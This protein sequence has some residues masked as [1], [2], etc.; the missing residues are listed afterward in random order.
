MRVTIPR[1]GSR[2]AGSRSPK[3]EAGVEAGRLVGL[4]GERWALSMPEVCS[5]CGE[6]IR[7]ALWVFVTVAFMC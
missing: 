1:L 3:Q 6:R 2:G 5:G 4:S 7:K